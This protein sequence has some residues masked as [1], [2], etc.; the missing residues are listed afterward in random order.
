MAL[1]W[2]SVSNGNEVTG[3]PAW[4]SGYLLT[5]RVDIVAKSDAARSIDEFRILLQH[6]LAER[7]DLMVHEESRMVAA[8]VMTVGPHGLK[9]KYPEPTEENVPE[10]RKL[11]APL[12]PSQMQFELR[13]MTMEF[14]ASQLSGLLHEP[15]IDRT[16]VTKP[17]RCDSW[18]HCIQ[19]R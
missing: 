14:L 19:I 12:G 6:L 15:I 2:R 9:V 1:P 17:S 3:G 16:G 7:F 5:D 4:I 13:S 18:R 8:Y 10:M 11:S